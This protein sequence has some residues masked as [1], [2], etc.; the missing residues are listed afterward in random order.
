MI[1]TLKKKKKTKK[2]KKATL[3][4]A[5]ASASILS[6]QA[7]R[8]GLSGYVFQ[9]FDWP[10]SP[11]TPILTEVSVAIAKS[12][13]A[14]TDKDLPAIGATVRERARRQHG[15]EDPRADDRQA[16]LR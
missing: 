15:V 10:Q 3:D 9:A 5:D 6:S 12:K 16:P 4:L 7:G 2:K 8:A 1:A 13:K 14:L 11:D